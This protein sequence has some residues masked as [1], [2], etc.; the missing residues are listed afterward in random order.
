MSSSCGGGK[1]ADVMLVAEHGTRWGR[2]MQGLIEAGVS[3]TVI[4]QRSRETAASFAQRVGQ[5]AD[6]LSSG[7]RLPPTI[8]FIASRR[9]DAAIARGRGAI[10]RALVRS[11]SRLPRAKPSLS[12]LLACDRSTTH[13]TI[14]DMK[15]IASRAAHE[16]AP[17][18]GGGAVKVSCAHPA[19]PIE[20]G[21]RPSFTPQPPDL[22]LPA[23]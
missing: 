6:A 7:K 3:V 14:L 17:R 5:R 11:L 9:L 8:F 16:L 13:E 2:W 21:P 23:A 4:V 20:E 1:P 19:A 22:P 15:N 12:L 10:A 18:F